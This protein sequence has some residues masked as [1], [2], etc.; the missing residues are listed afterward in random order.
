MGKVSGPDL[1]PH[2][3]LADSHK[4]IVVGNSVKTKGTQTELCVPQPI[5]VSPG[6]PLSSPSTQY[7]NYGALISKDSQMDCPDH[8]LQEYCIN[9]NS[10]VSSLHMP[11][12]VEGHTVQYLLDSGCTL[13]L[14]AKKVFDRL[15][16]K[17]GGG[18]KRFQHAK[19]TL[20]DGSSL[21]L[22]GQIELNGRLKSEPIS[23]FC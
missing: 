7:A 23:H 11:G 18:L 3:R 16:S 6:L 9:V 13:N 1:R 19:G 10:S 15:S 14:L 5:S 4:L 2:S 12:K 17:F 22:Y 8:D 20:A 21:L